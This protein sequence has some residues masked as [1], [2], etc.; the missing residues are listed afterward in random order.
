[1]QVEIRDLQNRSVDHNILELV[2]LTVASAEQFNLDLMSLVLGDN[3][4]IERLNRDLRS[5]CGTTDVIAFEAETGADGQS[6]AEAYIS[7]PT[8]AAQATDHGHSLIWELSFLV[9]HAVL[10]AAGYSDA[11]TQAR[12]DMLDRQNTILHE[13][14]ERIGIAQDRD[15]PRI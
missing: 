8:A 3:T 5:A 1:M 7:V 13:C 11:T 9:A 2:A 6:E 12:A 14:K 4:T 15:T 10:H